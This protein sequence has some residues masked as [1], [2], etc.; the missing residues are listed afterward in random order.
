MF[1]L[2]DM[3]QNVRGP[4]LAR[5]DLFR[6]MKENSLETDKLLGEFEELLVDYFR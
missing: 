4:Y 1:Q 2:I 6:L 3:G 5:L